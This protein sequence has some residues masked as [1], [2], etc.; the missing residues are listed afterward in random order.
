MN[1]IVKTLGNLIV[2]LFVFSANAQKLKFSELV[3]D[4]GTIQEE[5]GSV[6]HAF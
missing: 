6:T 2:M 1:K 4:F 3:H 5:T